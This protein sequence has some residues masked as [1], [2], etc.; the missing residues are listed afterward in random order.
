MSKEEGA[1]RIDDLFDS[2][3]EMGEMGGFRVPEVV[4]GWMEAAGIDFARYAEGGKVY[5]SKSF[6]PGANIVLRLVGSRAVVMT[7]DNLQAITRDL[8]ERDPDL[9]ERF[10]EGMESAVRFRTRALVRA[11]IDSLVEQQEELKNKIEDTR[12]VITGI[13]ERI[14]EK[15][16][17]ISKLSQE[18]RAELQT[19]KDDWKKALAEMSGLVADL[20]G[21]EKELAEVREQS[22]FPASSPVV[23][24]DRFVE[25]LRGSLG[26]ESPG[27]EV[28]LRNKISVF[29]NKDFAEKHRG[30]ILEGV[31]TLRQKILDN[32]GKELEE[33]L[34]YIALAGVPGYSIEQRGAL[35]LIAV[36]SVLDFWRVFPNPEN[37]ELAQAMYQADSIGMFPMIG[38]VAVQKLKVPDESEGPTSSPVSFKGISPKAGEKLFDIMPLT[39]EERSNIEV[40]MIETGRGVLH[41]RQ[42]FVVLPGERQLKVYLRPKT[43]RALE[44]AVRTG[45]SIENVIGQDFDRLNNETTDP[46]FVLDEVREGLGASSSPKPGDTSTKGGI[47]LNPAL[48]D[49]QIRRDGNGVPLPLPMQP[50][51][52]MHIEGFLPIIINVTPITNLPLLLGLADTKQDTG[53]TR[54]AM[55]AREPELISALN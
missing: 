28:K 54:P 42:A 38:E 37:E 31:R 50:I 29:V 23:S 17:R 53:E 39:E 40:V 55:K 20:R 51:Q 46:G 13:A 30:E 15:E 9:A 22:R 3:R 34:S 47:D 25:L 27:L 4:V 44:D 8:I 19:K 18:E 10:L 6:E 49:L 5:V 45:S 43:V 21:A 2:L 12:E 41:E 33:G 32:G 36:G 14:R 7:K 48:L 24:V 35:I 26:T 16:S 1:R 52:D 11:R